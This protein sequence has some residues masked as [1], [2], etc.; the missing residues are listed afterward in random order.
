[1]TLDVRDTINWSV[2]LSKQVSGNVNITHCMIK[3]EMC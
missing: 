2:S 3:F 1:M